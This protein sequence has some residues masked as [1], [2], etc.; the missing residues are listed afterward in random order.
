MEF[1]R[2][3]MNVSGVALGTWAMGGEG[4]GPVDDNNSVSAVHAALEH[5]INFIDTAP[6][7]GF[8]RAEEIVG[9]AIKGRRDRYFIATKCGL[10]W[11]GGRAQKNLTEASIVFELEH[12][13]RRLG[14]DYIDLYL[15]HWPDDKVSLEETYGTL[16]NLKKQGK[17]KHVGVCN[18][19]GEMLEKIDKITRVACVQNEYSFLKPRPGGDVFDYCRENGIG[20]LAYGPLAGGILTGKYD[21]EPGFSKSDTRSFFYRFYRGDAF[22]KARAAAQKFKQ[23]AA[24]Y[25][26]SAAAVAL[27]WTME[28][29]DFIVPL[30]GAKTPQQVAQNAQA[31]TL[32]L[33][34]EDVSFLNG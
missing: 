14:V 8:G 6:F 16:A 24:K 30:A 27:A 20:F 13:L 33:T 23:V 19:D 12:S 4:W 1:K 25:K 26:T 9:K 7:Y 18:V 2:E 22:D 29:R 15:T 5:G 17:I 31:L 3:K 21:R 10:L 32:K 28:Q 34:H 11:P